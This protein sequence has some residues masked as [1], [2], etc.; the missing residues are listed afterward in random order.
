MENFL[1]R[2]NLDQ[3]KLVEHQ[4]PATSGRVQ[5]KPKTIKLQRGA[6]KGQKCPNPKNFFCT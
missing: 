5:N 1:K 4:F 6:T 3:K 2:R